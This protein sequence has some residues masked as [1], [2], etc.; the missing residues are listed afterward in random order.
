LGP[1][2]VSLVLGAR[3]EKRY[4]VNDVM[5]RGLRQEQMSE[6]AVGWT[7]GVVRTLLTIIVA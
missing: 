7:R 6:P 1:F 5:S 4:R 2:K 3:R